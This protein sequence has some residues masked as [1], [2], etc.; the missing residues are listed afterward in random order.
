MSHQNPVLHRLRQLQTSVVRLNLGC[1][2]RFHADWLNLDI[3]PLAPEVLAADLRSGIP[4][5]NASCDAVYHCAVLEHLRPPEARF[6]LDECRR[7]LKKTG[8]L[9]VGIPDLEAISR[10][11]LQ[12]L[13]EAR[14]GV[15][16]AELEREWMCLEL[17]DQLAREKSGGQMLDYLKQNDLPHEAFIL[18]RIGEEGRSLLDGIRGH[19]SAPKRS[20]ARRIIARVRW[21]LRR[22][23]PS[24]ARSIGE[25]RLGGEAHQWMYDDF[26]LAALL[27]ECGFAVLGRR[28]A[29]Q[30]DI[31]DFARF[32]LDVQRD[33]TVNKPDCF[34]MEARPN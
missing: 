26:S 15:A 10:L 33:G 19:V 28:G 16:R 12:K 20:I 17:F 32:E 14:A 25:F 1:G 7:V 27:R 18:N 22:R 2:A 29:N 6:F 11:Y 8:I 13:D 9:R 24:E 4:L 5:P 21:I 31:P 3:A 34:F 30:S 23:N